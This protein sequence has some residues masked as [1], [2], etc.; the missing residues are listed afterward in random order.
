MGMAANNFV[1]KPGAT[2]LTLGIA[3]VD[4]TPRSSLEV[5]LAAGDIAWC[6]FPFHTAPGS[7]GGYPRPCLVLETRCVDGHAF[8]LV[9]YGT[10]RK[11]APAERWPGD[12]VFGPQ[13]GEHFSALGVDGPGKFRLCQ[14]ALLPAVPAY[15]PAPPFR[16]SAYCGR[17]VEGSRIG[18]LT[19]E[20]VEVVRCA[21][22]ELDL[23]RRRKGL[24]AASTV[25]VGPHQTLSGHVKPPQRMRPR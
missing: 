3:A 11:L 2:P 24:P 20:M 23:F 25:A 17:P 15:F 5:P 21:A 19:P 16:S 9:A 1:R 22:D 14:L 13:D 7:P 12:V 4:S 18:R 6:A 10:S 8:H